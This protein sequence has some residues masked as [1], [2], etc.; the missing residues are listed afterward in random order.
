MKGAKARIAFWYDF[1]SPYA[2]VAAERIMRLPPE[3]QGRFDWRPFLLGPVFAHHSA[4]GSNRQPM[5]EPARAN[6]WR[7]LDRLCAAFGI[8]W[9][10]QGMRVYPPR[11]LK[12]AR[13]MLAADAMGC[14]AHLALKTFR[15]AFADDRDIADETVLAQIAGTEAATLLPAARSPQ[16]RDELIRNGEVAIRAG[17]FGA[18]SFLTDGELFFGQDRLDQALCWPDLQSIPD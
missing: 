9:T 11:S 13:L 12:A 5:S 14:Q 7:D 16:I 10:G 3:Q 17:I 4:E 1:A 6:K 8:G 2:Y 18:P 15:A